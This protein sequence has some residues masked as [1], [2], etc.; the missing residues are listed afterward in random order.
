MLI[1]LERDS[2]TLWPLWFDSKSKPGHLY[3]SNHASKH[4]LKELELLTYINNLILRRS[5]VVSAEARHLFP[6]N[7][8]KTEKAHLDRVLEAIVLTVEPHIVL[9]TTLKCF[10]K[11]YI[12]NLKWNLIAKAWMYLK[13]L[14]NPWSYEY[15][16]PQS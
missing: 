15:I 4:S 5:Q 9:Q 3:A 14:R 8:V 13:Y 6:L 12:F 11:E 16:K 1:C 10:W 7:P 2:H